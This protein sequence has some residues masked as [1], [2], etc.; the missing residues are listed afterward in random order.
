MLL[1]SK[2]LF[3]FGG[4]VWAWDSGAIIAL[5]VIFPL[6]LVT[7]IFTQVYSVAT[8]PDRRLFPIDFVRVR[9]LVLLF[10]TTAS[11]STSLFVPV[12][13]IPLYFSFVHDASVSLSNDDTR[14]APMLT[15]IRVLVQQFISCHS[16]SSTSLAQC[17]TVF[18]CHDLD[19]TCLG[20]LFPAF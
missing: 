3:T 8:T 19:D 17:S 12:Y 15:K 10:A 20:T 1:K 4:A 5:F 14:Y 16:Y 18:S 13:Y 7:F 11:A 9:T 2:Q 6:I